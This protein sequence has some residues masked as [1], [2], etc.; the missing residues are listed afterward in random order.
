MKYNL[1]QCK[2]VLICLLTGLSFFAHAKKTAKP[3]IIFY[4]ADDQDIYDYGCY[5]ND[6]I[7]T[8]AVD[9][10]AKEGMLFNN[11]FTGQSI[12]APSRSQLFT[13]NYPLK[14]GCFINHFRTKPN[15]KSVTTYLG[16]LG[17]EVILAGK[18][19]V[20]PASVYDWDLEWESVNGSGPRKVIPMD[21]IQ[22]YFKSS[23][24]PFCMFISS[25]YPHGKYYDVE[26]KP[27]DSLQFYPFNESQKNSLEARKIKSGYYRNVEEDNSHLES[28]LQWVDEELDDNTLFIYSADHGVS[29]KYTVYDRGLNVPFVA[30]WPKV[31]KAGSYSDALV[32]YTDV[33]PTFIEMA[34]GKAIPEVDG[35]S[36]L[37]I[38]K[39]KD[40][41]IHDYVYGVQT[42]QGILA[43]S[44]FPARMIR[45][46]QYKYIRNL[47]ATEVV[48]Q[49]FGDNEY[50]N[51]FLSIGANKYKEKSYEEL[52]D[53]VDDPFEQNNLAQN[54]AYSDIKEQLATDLKIWMKEQGDILTGEPGCMPI[55]LTKQ[56]FLDQPR[57]HLAVPD[58][59]QNTLKRE[60]YL[61]LDY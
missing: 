22:A 55:I 12:C 14:N 42:S 4:L 9:R 43:A 21:S 41:D 32:H 47:N 51:A 36:F 33:V 6:K 15:Q 60:D 48:E 3:N 35:K 59:L 52:Y 29:G 18:S 61:I 44:V 30:R 17:Y 27:A 10:L 16:D 2:L 8:P 19:H 56:F 49:N 58:S 7:H 1:N 13:G 53:I 34:G 39:G 37:P 40:I 24:K 57:K 28:V 11:A 20:K 31:V 5:G 25:Y 23:D 54:A 46:K 38:L 45:N 50:V 26:A